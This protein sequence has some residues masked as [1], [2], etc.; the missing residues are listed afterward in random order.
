MYRWDARDY[1]EH[2]LEQQKWGKE[3]IQ[4]LNLKGHEKVL[5]IG[6]GDGKV[7]A[8]IAACVPEGSV[9]GIDNS[10]EMIHLASRTFLKEKFLNLFFQLKDAR[11]LDFNDEFD[12]VI[13]NASLHWVI[14]HL[15]V[16]RGIRKSLKHSGRVLIQMGGRGNAAEIIEVLEMMMKDK[17]WESYFTRFSFPYGFYDPE[18]YGAW[19]KEAG[20]KSKRVELIPK[21][22]VHQGR[23]GLSTWIRTTW[24]PYTQRVPETLRRE[25]IE[26]IVDRYI[27][28]LPIAEDGTIHVQMI[29]LEVEA[30]CSP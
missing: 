12:I 25:F 10:E 27:K 19:L 23:E 9:I 17:K 11:Y 24:L 20:L 30:Y 28:K 15:L 6:C 18:E 3:L 7:T 8:E 1:Q 5:D 2:S 4:K 22:M 14:D 26:E 13:S 29:R 16:L 21:D